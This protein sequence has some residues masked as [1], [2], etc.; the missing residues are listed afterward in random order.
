MAYQLHTKK[1]DKQLVRL[2]YCIKYVFLVR[3]F[4][5]VAY[6]R[7]VFKWVVI[8]PFIFELLNYRLINALGRIQLIKLARS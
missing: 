5:S 8:Y 7:Q 2:L 6:V 3:F 4:L 1:I